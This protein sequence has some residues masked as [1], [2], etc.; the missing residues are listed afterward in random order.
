M[1]N[2]SQTFRKYFCFPPPLWRTVQGGSELKKLKNQNYRR[3]SDPRHWKEV[4]ATKG[5]LPLVIRRLIKCFDQQNIRLD[6]ACLVTSFKYSLVY[7][8]EC[9]NFALGKNH[10]RGCPQKRGRILRKEL[11]FDPL[12]QELMQSWIIKEMVFCYQNCSDLL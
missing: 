4:P 12:F 10:F 1:L 8:T 2:G 11:D 9:R 7:S 3:F 6:L 5:K